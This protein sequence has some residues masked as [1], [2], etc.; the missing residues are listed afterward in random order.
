M[1][2]NIF[3]CL[4]ILK[5]SSCFGQDIQLTQCYANPTYLNPAYAGMNACSRFSLIHR[6]QWVGV[7]TAYKTY[8]ASYDHMFVNKNLGLG[9]ICSSDNSGSG[10]LKSNYISTSIA[11]EA[12]ITRSSIFRF[13]IQ[14]GFGTKTVDFSKLYFG[15]QIIRGGNVSTLETSTAKRN[16]FDLSTGALFAGKNFW[17][18]VSIS[19]FTGPNVSLHGSTYDY[20]PTKYTLHAGKKFVLN[21]FERTASKQ[22]SLTPTVI[23]KSQKEFDQMDIGLYY[24]KSFFSLGLWYRGLPVVKRYK[25]GY[26]LGLILINI[27]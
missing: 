13:A 21:K 18:G 17:A 10:A 27:K 12:S 22:K 1:K 16:Y 15:D 5:I 26:A 4:S 11:Y 23:Y 2:K 24:N 6:N 25:P 3:I 8:M 14:P 9:V 20:L 7:S 19:H